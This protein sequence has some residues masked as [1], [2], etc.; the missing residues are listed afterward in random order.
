MVSPAATRE[1]MPETQ[2]KALKRA[3][4]LSWLT[5]AYLVADTIVL[6]LIKGNSQAMQAAW[7]Q[8][9][10]A[11]IPPLAFLIG[12]RV[13]SR[14]A[15]TRFPYGF[16]QA[17]DIAHFVSAVALLAFG[18][19]LLVQSAM[20]LVTVE[21]PGIGLMV[22]FG[23]EIW[24]GWIMV[25]VMALGVIP[26]LILGRLKLGPAKLLHNKVLFTD[27][28][29][30]K[31]DWLSSVAAIV[32][33]TG[34][35]LGIW[36]MDAVAAIV[37]SLDILQDGYQN[38]RSSLSGLVDSIPYKLGGSELHPLPARLNRHLADLSWVK[39]A[40]CR[41]REEGQ[42]FHVEAFVVLDNP[43]EIPV[44]RLREAREECLSLDW[45]IHDVTI[46]PVEELPPLVQTD[47][48]ER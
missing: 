34:V 15:S 8:D 45:K 32:G 13:I 41:V 26:P 25:A 36:W 18:G 14:R 22:I 2:Q 35:G 39:E 17:Q 47:F 37:I 48:V 6:F 24:H 29:M 23:F 42:V 4:M 20:T 3:V 7:V 43:A 28:K 16:H 9:L 46:S 5:I 19:F 30:N 1:K 11:L 10:L 38:L 12:T 44:K 27:S 40:G 21:R 33:I 31:A